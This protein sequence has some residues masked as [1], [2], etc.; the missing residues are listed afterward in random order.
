MNVIDYFM[1]LIYYAPKFLFQM[2]YCSDIPPKFMLK[3]GVHFI[4]PIGIVIGGNVRIGNN[5]FIYKGVTLGTK[6]AGVWD[7]P[8]IG[9]NVTIYSNAT[10]LGKVKIGN[11]VIIGAGSVVLE[12][13][14]DNVT[15]AGNPARVI[16]VRT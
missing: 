14:R 10:I 3:R 2:L 15:V 16:K 7:F 11:N 13:V 5:V 9:D 4:H 6:H 8:T 12:D 1:Q